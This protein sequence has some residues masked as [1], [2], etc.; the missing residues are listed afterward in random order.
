[1]DM[2]QM[3]EFQQKMQEIQQKLDEIEV[4]GEAE[5]GLVKVVCTANREVKSVTLADSLMEDGDKEQIEDL[6]TVAMNRA[7]KQAEEKSEEEMRNVA[8]GMLPGMG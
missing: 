6:T 5:N 2:N 7:L 4:T 8:G 3:Q 1:M